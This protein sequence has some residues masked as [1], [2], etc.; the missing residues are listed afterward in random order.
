MGIVRKERLSAAARSPRIRLPRP[1]RIRIAIMPS[2]TLL[3]VAL[4]IGGAEAP[5][6]S[7]RG[8]LLAGGLIVS[9]LAGHRD[10][11]RDHA[12]DLLLSG[13]DSRPAGPTTSG[14]T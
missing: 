14:E 10:G 7:V 13:R 12:L 8:V 2:R 11:R 1:P 9:Y 4:A 5:E 3:V 6:P